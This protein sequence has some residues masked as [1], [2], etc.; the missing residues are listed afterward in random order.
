MNGINPATIIGECL[1][2]AFNRGGRKMKVFWI[3]LGCFMGLLGVCSLAFVVNSPIYIVFSGL[4][5]YWMSICFG[6]SVPKP[7]GGSGHSEG[8]YDGLTAG[9]VIDC[10]NDTYIA[11]GKTITVGSGYSRDLYGNIYDNATNETVI[12]ARDIENSY[13]V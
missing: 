8:G 5:L 7:H 9:Q 13:H 11:D 10:G 4:F 3:A 1:E 12:D 2:T 6:K